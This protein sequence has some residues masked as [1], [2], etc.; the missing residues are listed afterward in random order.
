MA[1]M[2]SFASADGWAAFGKTGTGFQFDR[3]GTWNR[4]RQFGWFVGWAAKSAR[5]IVF[6]RLLKDDERVESSAGLRA[7]D[8]MLAE[9]PSRLTKLP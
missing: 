4:D 5:R 8:G 6:V 3:A 9:L 7:R 1:I 2:P